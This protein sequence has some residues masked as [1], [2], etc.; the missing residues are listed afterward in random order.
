MNQ[1]TSQFFSILKTHINQQKVYYY[2]LDT[3]S[4]IQHLNFLWQNNLIWGYKS[5]SK[6]I[7]V[8]IKYYLNKGAIYLIKNYNVFL[9]VKQ[10]KNYTQLN[11]QS[12]LVFNTVRGYQSAQY[13]IKNNIGGKLLVKLN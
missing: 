5:V 4:S 3:N 2:L 9:N 12:I 1:S 8:Y 7:K 13:C 10:I 11:P 6:F